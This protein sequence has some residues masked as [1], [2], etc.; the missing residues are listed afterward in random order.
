MNYITISFLFSLFFCHH[1]QCHQVRMKM[2]HVRSGCF[3]T[4]PKRTWS[5]L[6]HSAVSTLGFLN[7]V[8]WSASDSAGNGSISTSGGP[9]SVDAFSRFSSSSS[10][11][12]S[13][14]QSSLGPNFNAFSTAVSTAASSLT[15]SPSV[16][17]FVSSSSQP[18]SSTFSA[19]HH[20]FSAQHSSQSFNSSPAPFPQHSS[21]TS[22]SSFGSSS[23]AD[24]FDDE[25]DDDE[26]EDDVSSSTVQE[27]SYHPPLSSLRK[28]WDMG[29]DSFGDAP[30]GLSNSSGF[31]AYTTTLASSSFGG[32]NK[33]NKSVVE[34]DRAMMELIPYL[35]QAGGL[36]SRNSSPGLNS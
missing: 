20:S 19:P 25:D 23:Y 29:D 22:S 31:D 34:N 36:I 21:Q 12:N 9:G 33:S 3:Q 32:L 2:S 6:S 17:S 35:L 10:G 15:S 11:S 26:F 8:M 28:I 16:F 30:A 1:Q 13:L 18:T 14:N 24:E 4:T 7:L 27:K 5:Q